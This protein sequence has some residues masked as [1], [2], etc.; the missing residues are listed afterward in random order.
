MASKCMSTKLST[1]EVAQVL[2]KVRSPLLARI[3]GVG[4]AITTGESDGKY[5]AATTGSQG[6]SGYSVEVRVSSAVDGQ[7]TVADLHERNASTGVKKLDQAQARRV[8]FGSIEK[9]LRR[10]DPS[11]SSRG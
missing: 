6:I 11:L 7:R 5:I 2:T 1:E 3:G 8:L 4:I 10:A 9:A